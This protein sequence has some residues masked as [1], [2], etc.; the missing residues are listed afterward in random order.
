MQPLFVHPDIARAKTLSKAFYLDSKYFETSREAIFCNS[1]QWLASIDE[2]LQPTA[3]KPYT[4]LEGFLDEPVA[5]TCDTDGKIHCISNVCTHRGAMLINTPCK[6]SIIRCPYHGRQFALN[7]T[8]KSMPEF[9]GVADFPTNADNLH[10]YALQSFAGSYFVNATGKQSFQDFFEP[11]LSRLHWL[12]LHEFALDPAA[13]AHYSIDA[14][15]AL[16]CEN[17]LEGF[18][19]PFVHQALNKALDFGNYTTELYPL[20]SLQLGIAKG[21]EDC[22][23]LPESSVDYGKQVAA[24][25]YFVFPN[26]MFNFYPWGLSL[27]VVKPEATAKTTVSFYS[28]VWK[29]E[30]QHSGAGGDLHT[31]E[32]ED[33]EIV[34]SV[35]KGIRSSHYQHGR[36]SVAHEKGTHHF[37]QLICAFMQK[38]AEQ[39]KNDL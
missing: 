6:N 12:P 1:W 13:T 31:T 22:F 4:L 10:T 15:W 2:P 29:P 14:H 23:A 37:H 24:Y 3:C 17:Y 5:L 33:E 16:Y 39:T 19:I 38:H 34:L 8:F 25:Y 28:Y 18:H 27:N 20:A 21:D 36:Y 35:Q 32:M 26:L 11:I 9:E 7:G 30:K